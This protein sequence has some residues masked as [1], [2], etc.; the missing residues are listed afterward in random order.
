MQVLLPVL[1]Y[2]KQ[3]D[4][5]DSVLE[6]AKVIIKAQDGDSASIDAV[7]DKY[8]FLAKI[9]ARRYFLLGGENE[10]LVQEGMI[11]LYKALLGYREEKGAFKCFAANCIENQIKTAIK[12][13]NRQKNKVLNSA[14][15]LDKFD[16]TD[17]LLIE[18]PQQCLI[19]KENYDE[20]FRKINEKLSPL[21]QK[22]LLLY[23]SGYSY[24]EIKEKV[25]ITTKSVDNAISRI[26]IKLRTKITK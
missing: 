24:E 26:K 16:Y 9:I 4:K 10:D 8:K 1:Y 14:I 15:S 13:A 7:M 20:R 22:V 5:G 2:L 12:N 19:A 3:S 6:E 17:F 23:L 18:D 11:G 25:K 21:E